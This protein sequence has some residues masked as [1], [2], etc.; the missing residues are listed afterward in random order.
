MKLTPIVLF[1]YNRPWH[2]LQTI[3]ALKKNVLAKKSELFIYSDGPKDERDR[4]KV[5]EVRHYLRKITGFKKITII[6]RRMNLGLANSII[7]GVSEIVNK[8]GKIIVLEDDLLT[9]PYFLKFMNEGL[10]FYEKEKKIASIHGYIYPVKFK[11]SET[12]LIRGADCWGWATWKRGWEL[13]EPDG[14]KLLYELKKRKLGYKFDLAG[15][16]P[17]TKMLSDQVNRKNDSWAIR[18]HA[19]AF[20]KDKL[21]LYPGSS[22]IFHNGN[23]KSGT[24]CK[25]SNELDVELSTRPIKISKIPLKENKIALNAITEYFKSTYP[26][27]R[28][29]VKLK[30]SIISKLRTIFHPYGWHGNYSSWN[31]AEKECT[32][33]AS[34]II[35][36][37]VKKALLKV[38]N[39]EAIYER[40]SVLFDHIE[41][42]WPLLAGLMWIAAKGN[43]KLNIIDF[44][45]SL[46]STYYQNRNFLKELDELRWNIVEQRKFVEYGKKYFEDNQL[47]FYSDIEKCI[48]ENNSNA[49]LFSAVIQYLEKPHDLIKKILNFNFEYIIIDRIGVLNIGEDRLTVQKVSPRIY[50]ASYPCWFFNEE[51]FLGMFMKKYTLITDFSA[52]KGSVIN[53]GNATAG[54]KGYIFKLNKQKL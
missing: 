6:E 48:R 25:K 8:Y 43:N 49:I 28:S 10:D 5:E 29:I 24:N 11:L 22:L 27:N 4:K 12:F 36:E 45:G 46:G 50:N 32:G 20:L 16:Y 47:K 14:K 54:W 41:Y 2:T 17:Y 37:K 39:V 34:D 51:K 18:W 1:V 40:D 33:Y 53:L 30:N 3:E 26:K 19:S 13:F 15:S 7:A 42:S 9:S 38:K 44:G 52:E 31:E 21:T 23:D 35:F